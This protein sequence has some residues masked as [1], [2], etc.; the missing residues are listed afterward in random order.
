MGSNITPSNIR[1][2]IQ[3]LKITKDHI[4]QNES[5]FTEQNPIAGM[6]DPQGRYNLVV[7]STGEQN[8]NTDITITTNRSGSVGKQTGATFTMAGHIH[9]RRTRARNSRFKRLRGYKRRRA[10][11]QLFISTGSK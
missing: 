2:F 5:T 11:D 7:S 3:P 9:D 6:P 4:W 10:H 8:D 1:G